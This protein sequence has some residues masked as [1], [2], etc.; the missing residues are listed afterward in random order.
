MGFVVF[1]VETGR[2]V[3]Y[4]RKESTAKAQVTARTSR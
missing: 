1:E 4:Y 2:A 3:K